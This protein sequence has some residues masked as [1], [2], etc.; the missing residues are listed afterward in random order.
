VLPLAADDD[1]KTNKKN[2][3]D[4]QPVLICRESIFLTKTMGLGFPSFRASLRTT[5]FQEKIE[6]PWKNR[7]FK[8]TVIGLSTD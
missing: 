2:A 5:F 3:R 1:V 8:L 7:V 6:I 4:A